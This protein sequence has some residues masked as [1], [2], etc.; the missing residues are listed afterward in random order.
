MR[1]LVA[2]VL[3]AAS[4]LACQQTEERT[5]ED[6]PFSLAGR[7]LR[8]ESGVAPENIDAPQ[9]AEEDGEGKADGG[10]SFDVEVTSR[11]AISQDLRPCNVSGTFTILYAPSTSF[12]PSDVVDADDF[13]KNLEGATVDVE[14]QLQR[15]ATDDAATQACQLVAEAVTVREEAEDGPE[16]TATAEPSPGRPQQG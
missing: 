15:D 11:N 9:G 7:V 5:L 10:G 12:E 16:A 4:A 14:G 13:P 1:P 2:A 6:G 3:L 8:T